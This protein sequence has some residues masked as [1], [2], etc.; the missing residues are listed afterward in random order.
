MGA[1]GA[2]SGALFDQ[3]VKAF[4]NLGL[5]VSLFHRLASNSRFSMSLSKPF[6]LALRSSIAFLSYRV[7]SQT[8]RYFAACNA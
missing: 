2:L 3:G 5:Q 6:S 4:G 1:Q 7:N 8:C